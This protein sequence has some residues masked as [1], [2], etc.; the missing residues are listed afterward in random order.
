[1][2]PLIEI[3]STVLFQGDS[4]TDAGRGAMDPEDLGSGYAMMAASWFS[5]ACPEL[6]VRFLNRGISGNRAADLEQRWERDCLELK[7]DWVS[8]MI[9]INDTWRAFD[10]GDPT[11]TEA[12]EASY[13]TIL[14]QTREKLGAH[15]IL[16]EPFVLPFPE[17][18]KAWRADLDPRI[19]VVRTLADEFDA[20]LV[21]MD[22]IMNAAAEKRD[23]AF[24]AP[25]GVHPTPAGHALIAQSWLR[26]VKAIA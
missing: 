17:D 10:S 19:Q 25:D 7:P 13:R 22:G 4:I 20:I 16:I 1:M 26:A 8:V 5:A 11:S 15:L 3:G 14:N 9:G 2:D 21:P 6:N 24:W 12:F 18:R 23:P